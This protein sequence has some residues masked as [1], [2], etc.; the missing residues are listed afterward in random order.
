M[1]HSQRPF[2]GEYPTFLLMAT[3]MFDLSPTVYEIFENKRKI[4]N[5]DLENEG[6]GKGVENGTLANGLEMYECM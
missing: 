1:Q 3:V 4:Q 2:D 5:F 6:Q